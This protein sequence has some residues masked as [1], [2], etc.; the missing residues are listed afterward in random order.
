[1]YEFHY[2]YTHPCKK[3]FMG[4]DKLDID[5][6]YKVYL[7]SPLSLVIETS[8]YCSGYML[9]DT[10]VPINQVRFDAEIYYDEKL[11]RLAYNTKVT[12][13]H[14]ID[15]VKANIFKSKIDAEGTKEFKCLI[16]ELLLP[17]YKK[18]LNNQTKLFYDSFQKKA[19]STSTKMND[20]SKFVV[21][22]NNDKNLS[23]LINHILARLDN[24]EKRV[25]ILETK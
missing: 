21:Y 5:D 15:F 9:V 24:L 7:I 6:H 20:N 13:S 1:M 11:K 2:K 19:E 17:S 16:D 18:V 3:V 14:T 25:E 12:I 4:P 22:Q 8:A 10:F 23:M